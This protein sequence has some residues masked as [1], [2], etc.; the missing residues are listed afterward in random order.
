MRHRGAMCVTA[1][2]LDWLLL[3]IT[4]LAPSAGAAAWVE[5]RRG[6]LPPWRQDQR[7]VGMLL[8]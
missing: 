1:A 2:A 6:P 7:D 5:K 3:L 8:R 4:C